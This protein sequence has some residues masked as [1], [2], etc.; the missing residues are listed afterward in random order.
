MRTLR[1]VLGLSLAVTTLVVP[2]AAHAQAAPAQTAAAKEAA[3]R[4]FEEGA[5][6]EK[7]SEYFAAL[8]KYKEAEQITVTPGLRFHKGYCLEMTGQLSAA[9]DE[10]EAA[11]KL[12]RETNRPEVRA[13]VA[14]RLEPVRARIPQIAIRVATQ[15][16]NVEVHVDG[17]PVAAG[18]LDGKSFRV[19]PGE[20]AITA[21]APGFKN[22]VRRVQVPESVTTTVDVTLERAPVA[23][24]PP[25]LSPTPIAPTP[26]APS[27]TPVAPTVE[28]PSE[29][30]PRRSIALPVIATV[31]TVALAGAGIAFFLVSGSAQSDAQTACPQKV[32]C[33]DEQS[34]VRTFD[35]LAL[36]SFIG[37]AGLGVVSA[38]LWSRSGGDRTAA[39]VTTPIAGGGGLR[40]EGSF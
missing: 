30:P 2:M 23:A 16:R 12:A 17:N 6:L 4:L 14:A 27:A 15:A 39:I 35:A 21:H 9:V 29:P 8:A 5:E 33:E 25:P 7:R 11:D 26:I 40:L 36:G 1:A 18:L 19:D 10:Y 34:K 31:G 3:K 28:P 24:A 22:F 38:V 37:A 20:H 13:A 32:A